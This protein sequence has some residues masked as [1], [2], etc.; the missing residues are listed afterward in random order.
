MVLPD[1]H[2]VPRVPWYLGTEYA[3]HPFR[4]QDFHPLWLAFPDH[5]AKDSDTMLSAPQPRYAYIAV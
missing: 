4:L 1:S 5:S 2:K 3:R